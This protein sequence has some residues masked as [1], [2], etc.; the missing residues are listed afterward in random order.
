[1]RPLQAA[2]DSSLVGEFRALVDAVMPC[3]D[4]PDLLMEVVARAG[5]TEAFTPYSGAGFLLEGFGVRAHQ[6]PGLLHLPQRP[7]RR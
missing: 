4:L 7:F 1:M 3:L 5:F 2:A 6:L